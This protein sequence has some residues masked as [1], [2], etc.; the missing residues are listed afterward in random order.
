MSDEHI[1]QVIAVSRAGGARRVEKPRPIVPPSPIKGDPE[2]PKTAAVN[3]E[4][5]MP[6]S[7]AMSLRAAGKLER[8]TLTECGWVLPGNETTSPT[9]GS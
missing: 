6:Y 7:R 9:K 1:D 8:A 4:P 3:A 2:R 5:E